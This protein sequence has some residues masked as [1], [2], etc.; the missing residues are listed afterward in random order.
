MPRKGRK[1][2]PPAVSIEYDTTT[3][4]TAT[5]KRAKKT[6][7]ISKEQAPP[8]PTT[9]VIDSPSQHARHQEQPCSLEKEIVSKPRKS[10]CRTLT[11]EEEEDLVAWLRENTFLYDKS[12]ADFKLKEKKNRT[13]AAK[14]E[15]LGLKAG[16]LSSIWYPNMR[17]QFFSRLFA[18]K[19]KELTSEDTDDTNAASDLSVSSTATAPGNNPKAARALSSLTSELESVRGAITGAQDSPAQTGQ[20]LVYFMRQMDQQRMNLF[21]TRST[22]LA[23]DLV[24]ESQEEKRRLAAKQ[25]AKQTV[26]PL[27]A[28][29][30]LP[31]LT[32]TTNR[33]QFQ[34]SAA[35]G[36]A[37]QH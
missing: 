19:R 28:M 10:V 17:T 26:A 9:P 22:R 5:P 27:C 18:E 7:K 37:M 4:P 33:R 30:T 6:K 2:N 3:S 34:P 21:V 8:T 16:D 12:S 20:F 15:E 35:T 23:L 1:V 29:P 14:E 13:W 24:D 11:N 31:K 25:A 36:S 32:S